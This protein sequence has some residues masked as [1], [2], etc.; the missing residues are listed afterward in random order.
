MTSS[1]MKVDLMIA[2]LKRK[3]IEKKKCCKNIFF[4]INCTLLDQQ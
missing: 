1:Y 3:G 4:S 2:T